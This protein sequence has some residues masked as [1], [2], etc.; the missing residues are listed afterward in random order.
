MV[1]AREGR[2]RVGA[3]GAASAA[4]VAVAAVLVV[5]SSLCDSGSVEGSLLSCGGDPWDMV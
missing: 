5:V 4:V 1:Q 2:F 3:G